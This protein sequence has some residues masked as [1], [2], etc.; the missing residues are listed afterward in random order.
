MS[1]IPSDG[2]FFEQFQRLQ[3]EKAEKE[4]AEKSSKRDISVQDQG[5]APP[6]LPSS[7]ALEIPRPAAPD[8]PEPSDSD[9]IP[10]ASFTGARPGFIFKNGEQGLGEI[11]T[12]AMQPP[13]KGQY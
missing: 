5:E 9:F 10:S 3:A 13:C 11:L 6:P 8:A 12:E 7:D 1:S 4:E 2:S